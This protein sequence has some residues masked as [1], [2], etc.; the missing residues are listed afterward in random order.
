M[1]VEITRQIQMLIE[2]CDKIVT[3]GY[4]RKSLVSGVSFRLSGQESPH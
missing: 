4:V 2:V 3:V 1:I